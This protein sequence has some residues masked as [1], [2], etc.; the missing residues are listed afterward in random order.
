M[1]QPKEI[2]FHRLR[3]ISPNSALPTAPAAA[4]WL[5]TVALIIPRGH[6]RPAPEC[7]TETAGI[8]IPQFLCNIVHTR[9]RLVK[10]AARLLTSYR[11]H[12][13]AVALPVFP[14]PALQSTHRDAE[15][16]CC[17]VDRRLAGGQQPYNYFLTSRHRDVVFHDMPSVIFLQSV[18][19]SMISTKSQ[20][21]PLS[22]H[23]S[24]Y[25]YTG[26]VCG[27]RKMIDSSTLRKCR[28]R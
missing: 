27:V 7:T 11:V 8:F 14:E 20:L 12:E 6:T 1:W 2:A 25:L 18:S 28:S 5:S 17:A 4:P 24:A 15:L 13:L 26:V 9:S 21:Y 3:R 10:A 19:V 23:L 16:T 22:L